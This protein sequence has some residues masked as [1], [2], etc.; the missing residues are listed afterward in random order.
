MVREDIRYGGEG[1]TVGGRWRP[2]DL[3]GEVREDLVQLAG[4][5]PG[6]VHQSPVVVGTSHTGV[7]HRRG[8][9]YRG[10]HYLYCGEERGRGQTETGRPG[11][12]GSSQRC[13]TRPGRGCAGHVVQV[14]GKNTTSTSFS[15][16]FEV[17]VELKY[18]FDAKGCRRLLFDEEFV[19]SITSL[20]HPQRG[21][22]VP[23]L[24]TPIPP[25]SRPYKY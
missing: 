14:M 15:T 3:A 20:L 16:N 25:P 13:V 18:S 9:L 7:P 4:Q 8:E 5:H 11:R 24:A 12:A 21:G 6:L 1:Q 2:R 23:H 22:V 10:K 17:V 19:G